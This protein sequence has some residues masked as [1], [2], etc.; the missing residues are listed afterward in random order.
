M[1][2]QSILPE[3]IMIYKKYVTKNRDQ[4]IEAKTE[5]QG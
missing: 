1:T 4:N 2:Q 5:M 3:H